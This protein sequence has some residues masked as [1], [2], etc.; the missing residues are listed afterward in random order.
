MRKL[1]VVAAG[2]LALTAC[3]PKQ[4]AQFRDNLI[5]ARAGMTNC[6]V[7]MDKYGE[8]SI[9]GERCTED[10]PCWNCSLMGNH[11]CGKP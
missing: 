1:I 8:S 7:K 2:V 5:C 11:K 6:V 10:M 9:S 4:M 3:T